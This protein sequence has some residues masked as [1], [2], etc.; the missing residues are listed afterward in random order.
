MGLNWAEGV[1]PT[2]KGN[3]K[4]RW[5]WDEW[6]NQHSQLALYYDAPPDVIIICQPPT[7]ND[8]EPSITEEETK[9]D[10]WPKMILIYLLSIDCMLTK[11]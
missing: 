6:D 5:E 7:M 3:I 8:S 1:V 9:P 4:I 11:R 10:G 2:I